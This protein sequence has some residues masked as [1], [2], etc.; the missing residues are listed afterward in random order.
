MMI[1]PQLPGQ[2]LSCWLKLMQQLMQQLLQ[3]QY[4]RVHLEVCSA[5]E[6]GSRLKAVCA[7]HDQT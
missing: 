7:L 6:P 2:L 1:Y 4:L 5:H 3:V